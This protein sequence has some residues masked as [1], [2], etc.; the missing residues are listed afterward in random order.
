MVPGV[1]VPRAPPRPGRSARD[2]GGGGRAAGRGG[3]G[4]GAGGWRDARSVPAPGLEPAA[5]PPACPR[6]CAMQCG[7][8]LGLAEERTVEF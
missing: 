3:A 2:R 7:E 6:R 1:R 4:P 8:W 5:P